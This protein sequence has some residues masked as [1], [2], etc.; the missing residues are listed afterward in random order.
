MKYNIWLNP[1]GAI[2]TRPTGNRSVDN[3]LDYID[4]MSPMALCVVSTDRRVLQELYNSDKVQIEPTSKAKIHE[5]L[6]ESKFTAP[7]IRE[8]TPYELVGYI[9]EIKILEAIDLP[10]IPKD[11]KFHGEGSWPNITKGKKYNF[12]R[13]RYSYTRPIRKKK[14]HSDKYGKVFV[15]DHEIER[16]GVDAGYAFRDDDNH[17]FVFRDN[18]V[19][20]G[21]FP[22]TKV[23]SFFGM[24]KIKTIA[25]VRPKQY[26]N[27]LEKM[28]LIEDL[29]GFTYYPGQYDYI[30][31][32]ACLDEAVIAGDVG[33]GKTCMA[34]SMRTLKRSKRTLIIAP[35]GT[36]K[37]NQGART[38]YNPSQ[39]MQEIEQFSPG[40]KVYKLFSKQDYLGLLREDGTLPVGVFI[41]YPNA[42]FING[43]FE[44]LP[45]KW[46]ASAR[47]EK[48]RERLRDMGINAEY[49]PKAPPS[50]ENQ[51]HSGV[52]QTRNGF[53]CVLKP[54]LSTISHVNFDMVILDEAHVMQNLGSKISSAIIRLQPKYRYAMTATPIPNMLPNIFPILGW[55]AVPDW[56][57][58]ERSNPRWPYPYEGES[59]FNQTFMTRERGYTEEATRGSYMQPKPCPIIS[60]TQ[61]LLKVLKSIIAYISKEECNPDVVDCNIE[62]IK[63]PLGYQQ[64]QLYA[65]NLNIRNIPFRN[66]KTK[67]GVQLQRLRGICA[68]PMGRSFNNELVGSNFNPKLITTL[69]LVGDI[70]DKDEQV[71]I[72][73]ACI[74]QT[75]EIARRLADCGIKY[76]RIDSK[77]SNHARQST[78]F[79]KGRTKVCLF[80]AKCA[81]GHSFKDCSNMI[82]VSLEWSYGVFHQAIGR[83]YRLNSTKDAHIRILLNKDTIE[84]SMFEKLADKRDA[85]T[86]CLLGEYVPADFK[87]GNVDELMA[88]HFLTFNEEL[89]DTENEL[90]L[91]AKWQKLRGK[92][93]VQ[94]EAK[95]TEAKLA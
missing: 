70:L 4:G 86:T 89:V 6:H 46:S 52:G 25:D 42:F 37:D 45:R 32:L 31:R 21:E 59:D 18:P 41:T 81:V 85:A 48:F 26:Q 16:I 49:D 77:V 9:D 14:M 19:S 74:G 47:E 11:F 64:K 57:K 87:E 67:Y 38:T 23:W 24:P 60:Q 79:K 76:S 94:A 73:S 71:V 95:M 91:E 75:D 58:G 2:R 36:V 63:V 72:V 78:D 12:R 10:P 82:I 50:C 39:W 33:T 88:E 17:E 27:N 44:K 80:G 61:R 92:L 54:S 90:N 43:A 83:V 69:E 93:S 8:L 30:A 53:T 66:P 40:T 3:K 55:L 15:I 51:Y 5:A 20:K 7:P 65:K 56:Y 22:S 35:K 84:E 62:K 28:K 68:D 13:L 29:N 1:L 34:I